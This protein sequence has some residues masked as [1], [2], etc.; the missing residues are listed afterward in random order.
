MTPPRGG[1]GRDRRWRQGR[2]ATPERRTEE[3]T[4]DGKGARRPAWR[5]TGDGAREEERER[6]SS[7]TRVTIQEGAQV[8]PSEDSRGQ[9]KGKGKTK[10]SD[11]WKKGGSDA[12]T[13][14]GKGRKGKG[15]KG[16]SKKKRSPTPGR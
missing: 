4:G 6:S 11:G 1:E 14:K 12:S 2:E 8:I 5:R 3:Q 7:Q 13:S 10:D 16:K 15:P 9:A